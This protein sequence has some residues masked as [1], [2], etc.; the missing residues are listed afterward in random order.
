[1]ERYRLSLYTSNCA[2]QYTGES[3]HDRLKKNQD[4]SAEWTWHRILNSTSWRNVIWSVFFTMKSKIVKIRTNGC[5]KYTWSVMITVSFHLW[6]FGPESSSHQSS[7][8]G[9]L[10]GGNSMQKWLDDVCRNDQVPLLIA[11][12]ALHACRRSQG[13]ELSYHSQQRLKV[14]LL[15]GWTLVLVQFDIHVYLKLCLL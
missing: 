8:V 10:P 3:A 12:N 2:I 14:T 6:I 5:P 11:S 1:M 7:S 13:I 15:V 4:G 9:L